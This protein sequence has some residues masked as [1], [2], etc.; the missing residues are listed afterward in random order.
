MKMNI[1][2]QQST[3]NHK[4]DYETQLSNLSISGFSG[5]GAQTPRDQEGLTGNK[6]RVN[7]Y[8]PKDLFKVVL[9]APTKERAEEEASWICLST[10]Q[11]RGTYM[12][13]HLKTKMVIFCK[14]PGMPEKQT[15]T[16]ANEILLGY[17]NDLK[18]WNE[19]KDEFNKY[20]TIPVKFIISSNLDLT[21]LS[22]E[23]GAIQ[24][25]KPK[26]PKT[27][28]IAMDM[29]DREEY[30]RIVAKFNEFDIDNSGAI[31]SFEM[32]NIAQ[33][34][35]INHENQDFVE[36]LYALDLNN[37]GVISL[38][39]FITWWKVGRQNI[40][41]LPK[42]YNLNEYIKLIMSHYINYENFLKETSE[43]IESKDQSRTNQT[44]YFRNPGEFQ[45]KTFIE[46]SIA[47]GGPKRQ[48]ESEIFL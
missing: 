38:Y 43:L 11:I 12:C 16:V 32:I 8:E 15:T 42:I 39:E 10:T 44:I 46:A 4:Q 40:T 45:L 18:E 26:D 1:N 14:W 19:I 34:L 33:S 23:L 48:Q 29:Q 6:A 28:R 2:I 37:D 27:L 30:K 35:G 47:F 20:S 36:S 24:L 31:E 22:K 41:S 17:C 9:I 13:N 3:G 7:T 5:T 21:E 25:E